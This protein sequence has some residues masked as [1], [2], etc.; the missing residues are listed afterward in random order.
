MGDATKIDSLTTK[1]LKRICVPPRV[2][3]SQFEDYFPRVH[4]EEIYEYNSS[5]KNICGIYELLK[6]MGGMVTSGNLT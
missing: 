1:P 2:N 4:G 5:D 3:L 6:L